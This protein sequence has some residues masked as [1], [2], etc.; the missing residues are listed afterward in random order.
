MLRNNLQEMVER[1]KLA[2]ILTELGADPQARAEELTLEQWV[3]L[4]N[5]LPASPL[6]GLSV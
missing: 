1:E 3:K 4:S 2:E 5:A 6:A